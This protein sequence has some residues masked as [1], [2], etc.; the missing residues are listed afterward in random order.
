MRKTLFPAVVFLLAFPCWCGVSTAAPATKAPPNV[1]LFTLDTL[2]A[3][4]LGCYGYKLI[5]TPNLD[6]LAAEGVRFAHAYTPVPITLPSHTVMLTGTY[7]MRNGMHDFSGNKLSASLPTL[8]TLLHEEGYATGAVL[9]A[10]V[11]DSRFGLNRGFDFYYDHFDFSRLDERNLDAMERPGNEVV[12]DALNWLDGH[13]QKPFLLWVHLYDA[14]YPYDPPLPYAAKYRARPYD[15]EIAFVD[16]QVGRVIKYLKQQGLYANSLIVVA[17]DHGEGLGEHGEKTHGFFIYDSTLRVP[18]IFKLPASEAPQKHVVED[19]ANLADLLPTVL[20]VIGIVTPADVQG[21]SLVPEMEGKPSRTVPEDYAETYLPRIHFD[22][23]EL[24]GIRFRQYYFVDAPRPELYDTSSDPKE[25]KNIY[26]QQ[27]AVANE[28]RKRL[29]NFIA[30][31]SPKKG[32]KTATTTGLDPVL[33]ERLKSLGYVAVGTASDEVLSDRSLPDPK[34]RIHVYELV[35]DAMSDSQRDHYAESVAKLQQAEKTEK[36]S[37]PIEYLLGLN[38]LRMK[39]YPASVEKFQTVVKLS[40]TYALATF[41]LG[42][43]YANTGDFEQ[44]IATLEKALQLDGT[45]YSAAFNLGAAYLKTGNVGEA[46]AAFR[47]S[48]TINPNYAEG[49]VALGE[50]LLYEGKTDEAIAALREALRLEPANE[51][52]RKNLVKALR[53]KGL[54]SEADQEMRK[55][56]GTGPHF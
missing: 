40:P 19:P 51:R 53:A 49:N 44:A 47:R 7:P 18:L 39:N 45:N 21:K 10:A 11:L 50:V 37:I 27:R 31:Y 22:W 34:D 46:E 25:L 20:N 16:A 24:R 1:V 55:E 8:A 33:A 17:A 56:G 2:R 48:V 41:Y 15:G 14:H 35:S 43:A 42:L 36:D 12:N 4:H 5:E 54:D 30:E 3:D 9:G 32:E 28:L 6:A 23:S 38:Y 29:A 52:A 13:H 26:G